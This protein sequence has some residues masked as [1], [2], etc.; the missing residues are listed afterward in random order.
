MRAAVERTRR[1]DMRPGTHQRHNRQMQRGLAAG[2]RDRTDTALQRGN[3][4]LEHRVGGIA[5][6]RIDMTGALDIEQRGGLVRVAKNEG[7]ALVDG[8]RAGAGCRI[9][10][11]ARCLLYTSDAADERSSVDLGG[12]RIIKKKTTTEERGRTQHKKENMTPCRER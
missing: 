11:C 12:R 2:G 1:H 4:L 3:T 10:L 5:Q 6:P 9:G 7:G 8:G